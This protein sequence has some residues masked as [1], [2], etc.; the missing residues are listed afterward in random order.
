MAKKVI[1]KVYKMIII[2]EWFEEKK[3]GIYWCIE[4]PDKFVHRVKTPY[5]ENP[6]IR[7][8]VQN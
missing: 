6:I 5:K 3:D 4:L 1:H 7:V 8:D 2:K